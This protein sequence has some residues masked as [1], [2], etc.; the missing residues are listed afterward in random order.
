M[1][2]EVRR[3]RVMFMVNDVT[4]GVI[5]DPF[6]ELDRSGI[7]KSPTGLVLERPLKNSRRARLSAASAR[8]WARR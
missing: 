3:R 5:V 2:N 8:A 1:E 6:E 4:T 7:V